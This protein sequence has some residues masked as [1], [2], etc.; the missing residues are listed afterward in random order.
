MDLLER[1][2]RA[3]RGLRGQEIVAPVLPGSAVAARVCGLVQR[4]TVVPSG[5]RGWSVLRV[6]GDGTAAVVR[7]ATLSEIS[8]Y[9][10]RLPRHR[11]LLVDRNGERWL[12]LRDGALHPI[13][14][15]DEGQRFDHV[16]A[17]FDGGSSWFEAPASGSDPARAGW[18]REQWAAQV[19][20]AELARPGLT[21]EEVAAYTHLWDGSREPEQRRV[22]RALGHAGARLMSVAPTGDQLE[23]TFEL[24]GRP[25]MAQVRRSDLTVLAAG[26]CLSGLDDEFDLASLVAVLR[27]ADRR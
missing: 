24:D 6:R 16:W 14:L 26:I 5:H 11:F 13:G 10:E 1:I 4:L 2:A 9:M 27:E 19:A 21:P 20:P 15:V 18:L 8:K 17:R 3:E 7:A 23:V 22:E 12:G 25:R